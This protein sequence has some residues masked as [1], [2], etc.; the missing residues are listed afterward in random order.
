MSE[1][2]K[3]KIT[4]RTFRG[5]KEKLNAMFP[6]IGY[7]K[8]MRHIIHSFIKG[9]EEKARAKLVNQ[10]TINS[11]SENVNIGEML[12]AARKDADND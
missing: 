6:G 10:P 5:D 2:E 3:E 8:A 4:I 12:E 11:A 7:N 9:V 1:Q